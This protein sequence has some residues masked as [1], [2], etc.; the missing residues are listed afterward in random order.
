MWAM[1][2][3]SFVFA[4]LLRWLTVRFL[5]LNVT[6]SAVS[7]AIATMVLSLGTLRHEGD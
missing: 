6:G 7:F 1:F 4:F 3:L 5:P 2:L